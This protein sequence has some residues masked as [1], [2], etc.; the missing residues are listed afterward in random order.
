MLLRRDP[1]RVTLF[2][3]D[4]ELSLDTAT[5]TA[6]GRRYYE[7]VGTRTK[8]DGL[9]YLTADHHATALV[10]V[11]ASDSSS[12][13]V[14]RTDLFGNPRAG[15]RGGAAETAVSWRGNRCRHRSH[16]AG[17]TGVRPRTWSFPVA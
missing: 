8:A 13:D 1:G 17:S 6:M 10:A 12:M 5:G 2:V 15:Q 11:Q 7:G 14:R 9:V 4:G 3:G 16:S